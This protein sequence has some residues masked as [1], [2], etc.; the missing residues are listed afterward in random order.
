MQDKQYILDAIEAVKSIIPNESI[1]GGF[2]DQARAEAL[3][4]IVQA[5][6]ATHQKLMELLQRMYDDLRPQRAEE[7]E[8]RQRHIGLYERIIDNP[9]L[10]GDD[11]RN[12]INS[13]Q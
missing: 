12:L 2:G 6:E 7:S 5:R 4:N 11:K 10:D 9:D 1:N 8:Y 13:I 3:G